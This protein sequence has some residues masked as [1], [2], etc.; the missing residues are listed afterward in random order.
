MRKVVVCANFGA[1]DYIKDPVLDGY[2]PEWEYIYFTDQPEHSDIWNIKTVSRAN[3]ETAR[4]IKQMT[5]EWINYDVCLWIDASMTLKE[6]PDTLLEAMDEA[7]LLFKVHPNRST[8][9]EEID[10]CQRVGHF[11]EKDSDYL[12]K[13]FDRHDYGIEKQHM[14]LFETGLYI[15]RNTKQVNEFM[16]DWHLLT[17]STCHLRDQLALPYTLYKHRPNLEVFTQG[18]FLAWVEYVKHG[19]VNTLPQI[20]YVTPYASDGNLGKAYRQ[21]VSSYDNEEWVAICDGDM[22]FLDARWGKWIGETIAANKDYDIFCPMT[23]RLRDNQQVITNMYN[24][25]DV[26]L[27]RHIS[28]KLWKK[29]G[30]SMKKAE[31]PPAGLLMIAKAKVFR[32]VKFRNGLLLLDT[33]FMKRAAAKGYKIGIMQGVY[34]FHYYRMAEGKDSTAHLRGLNL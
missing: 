18:Q 8:T 28:A 6:N 9:F 10:A 23:N 29:K 4:Q 19:E 13:Y 7:D 33:D 27:H 5:H 1:R 16:Q 25:P 31:R 34:A 12:K 15:K 11:T 30:T 3:R 14:N 21:A 24:V 2:N 26:R 20:N 17:V 32:D 22:C